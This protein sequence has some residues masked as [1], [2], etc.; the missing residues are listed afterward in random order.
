M[1]ENAKQTIFSREFAYLKQ[2]GICAHSKS[3]PDLSA[4]HTSG[5]EIVLP[6]QG[7]SALSK[8]LGKASQIA[9]TKCPNDKA[10]SEFD[11]LYACSQSGFGDVD[12]RVESRPHVGKQAKRK[13]RI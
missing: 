11:R 2:I 9:A 4:L 7:Q 13:W 10:V 8:P 12:A 3:A 6:A 5:M 1:R